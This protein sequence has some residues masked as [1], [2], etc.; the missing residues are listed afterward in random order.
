M[1]RLWNRARSR[2]LL[3]RRILRHG[4]A[5]N[6]CLAS[7]GEEVREEATEGITKKEA[8]E[9]MRS[10]ASKE[11]QDVVERRTFPWRRWKMVEDGEMVVNVIFGV[12]TGTF[13]SF[14]LVT[15]TSD[16]DS[17]EA[18]IEAA[19]KMKL[20]APSLDHAQRSPSSVRKG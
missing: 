16:G 11:A 18:I 4:F 2:R 19:Q 3:R 6:G 15:G 10:H 7:L 5:Q 1:A 17:G 20:D 13:F 12:L 14:V 9:W 8:S